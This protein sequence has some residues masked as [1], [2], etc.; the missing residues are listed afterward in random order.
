MDI[1]EAPDDTSKLKEIV[2][3]LNKNTPYFTKYDSWSVGVFGW[4]GEGIQVYLKKKWSWFKSPVVRICYCYSP[5]FDLE[6]HPKNREHALAIAEA[7]KHF[8]TDWSN[9]NLEY[10]S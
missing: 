7:L 3:Y 9:V 4:P 1:V 5:D 2:E 8:A 6:A 10:R